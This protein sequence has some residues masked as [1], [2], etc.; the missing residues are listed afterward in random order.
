MKNLKALAFVTGFVLL[1]GGV[2]LATLKLSDRYLSEEEA[3]TVA[4]CTEHKTSYTVTIQGGGVNPEHTDAK[5]CDTFTITNADAKSRLMAFG[6]HTHHKEYDGVTT[7]M[8]LKDGSLKVT[9][10][11]LGTYTFHD[12]FQDEVQGSF[13]VTQ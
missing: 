10:N 6:V 11:E 1:V 7:K 3:P 9:L 8:L 4:S 13:T 2:I 12:H 5:L